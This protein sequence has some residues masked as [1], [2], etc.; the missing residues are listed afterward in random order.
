MPGAIS[1]EA[2]GITPQGDITGLYQTLDKK[3]HGYIVSKDGFKPARLELRKREVAVKELE[4]ATKAREAATKEEETRIKDR[5]QRLLQRAEPGTQCLDVRVPLAAR[6][7][8]CIA[9]QHENHRLK[10]YLS[11]NLSYRYMPVKR[12]VNI[13]YFRTATDYHANVVARTAKKANKPIHRFRFGGWTM[14]AGSPRSLS[15]GR[16]FDSSTSEEHLYFRGDQCRTLV[17]LTIACRFFLKLAAMLRIVQ[18][19]QFIFNKLAALLRGEGSDEMRASEFIG[20][21]PCITK[22]SGD[23]TCH[24]VAQRSR[25]CSAESERPARQRK[26]NSPALLRN[27][28]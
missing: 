5:E 12:I 19:V 8:F 17:R 6:L 16:L 20:E 26:A 21:A 27:R 25:D 11:G 14:E 23:P 22:S 28:D 2:S 18:A 9:Y 15:L 10:I 4:A 1:T 3:F 24:T 7:P 13:K